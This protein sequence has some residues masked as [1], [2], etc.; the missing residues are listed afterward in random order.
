M[1]F[2]NDTVLT[3]WYFLTLYHTTCIKEET[4]LVV[5][6]FLSQASWRNCWSTVLIYLI[7]TLN[8]FT[9]NLKLIHYSLFSHKIICIFCRRKYENFLRSIR[10]TQTSSSFNCN[11]NFSPIDWKFFSINLILN[12]KLI[13]STNY[14]LI[15]WL[16]WIFFT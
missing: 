11:C 16:I 3:T 2:V 6:R 1:D 4:S 15:L 12:M 10:Y 13:N 7:N 9:I 8:I 14:I 5:L